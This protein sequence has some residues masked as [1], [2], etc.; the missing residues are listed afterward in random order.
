MAVRSWRSVEPGGYLTAIL[1]TATATLLRLVLSG[2]LGDQAP[3]FPFVLAVLVTAWYAG[4]RPGLLATALGAVLGICFVQPFHSSWTERSSVALITALFLVIGVTASSLC[5]ALH[6]ARRRT[7]EKQRQLEQAEEHVRSVVNHVI[8]GIIAI[9]ES[10]TIESFN[11]AAERLFGYPASEVIGKNVKMLMP[12]AYRHEHDTYLADYLRT[13]KAKIIGI[14][15]EVEGRRKDG[16]TFPM[17]LA[18]SEFRIRSRRYFT[19][20]VRDITERKRA[21]EAVKEADR[22]KDEFLA[23]LAHELR[24]PLAPIRNAVELLRRAGGDAA[25]MEKARSLM[26]RQVGQMARLVDDLLDISRITSRKVQLRKERVG[27]EV[28]IRSA[29]EAA[30][31]L[32]EAQ[33]HELTVTLPPQPISL[34]ADPTRL[35]QVFSNLLNNAAK[36]TEKGGH[37]W[38]T[39]ER[40]GGEVIVSVRDTGIGITADYLPHIFEMFAQAV[41]A[42]ERSHGGLGVGLAL[43]KGL[44]ELHGGTIEAH[45]AGPGRGSE[46][47]VG[48]PVIEGPTPVA[49]E[50]SGDCQKCRS[51]PRCRILVV[52]D[53]RDT[54]DSLALML[55][56]MG[57]DIE[58]AHDGLEAVQA[59][60]TFLPDVVLLDIGLPKMNGYEAA[61]NIRQQSWGK[62]TILVALTGWGQEEDKRRATEAGFDHHLTKPVEPAALEKLLAVFSRAVR[63]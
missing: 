15:R 40:Q 23:T 29:V 3:F 56:L 39:A 52:D 45:S 41:P 16:S 55:R 17:E 4:L 2:V 35:A 13:G 36:Y 61:Q 20:I 33:A 21:E 57:H 18:V 49:P 26:E 8:D 44:V 32:I 60:A 51:M 12:E 7:E 58:M 24:N 34:D 62:S 9:D 47:I 22:R 19:G 50:P 27:L 46:F 28:V 43:V 14:G 38:L 37:I 11:P 5:G 31:P 10:G 53:N 25:L 48:L 54:A 30:R 6:A 59:A 1:A 42:L 63:S